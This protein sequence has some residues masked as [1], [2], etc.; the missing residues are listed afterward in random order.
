[1]APYFASRTF[2]SVLR[3]RGYAS[4][5]VGKWHLDNEPPFEQYAAFIKQGSYRNPHVVRVA[6]RAGKRRARTL[7]AARDFDRRARDRH[8]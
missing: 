5:M 2:V 8:K 1:V 4:A 7:L 6:R 3:A